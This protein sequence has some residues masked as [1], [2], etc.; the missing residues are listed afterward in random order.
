[1]FVCSVPPPYA[2][3]VLPP[4]A[5]VCSV[6]SPASCSV[7]PPHRFSW[8]VSP[9]LWLVLPPARLPRENARA[10]S[11]ATAANTSAAATAIVVFI[12]GIVSGQFVLAA[13]LAGADGV[14]DLPIVNGL[15][16]FGGGAGAA[17][18]MR[19]AEATF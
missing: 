18:A 11:E 1:M 14:E 17:N 2:C 9:G 4:Y 6:P 16:A 8:L 15:T 19:P 10:G 7:L 12:M 3:A 5:L 13:G